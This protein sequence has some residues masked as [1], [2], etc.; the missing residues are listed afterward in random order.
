LYEAFTRP[1]PGRPHAVV[2]VTRPKKG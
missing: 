2:A 1:H